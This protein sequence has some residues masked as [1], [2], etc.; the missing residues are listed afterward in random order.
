M[1]MRNVD[2]VVLKNIMINKKALKDTMSGDV[3]VAPSAHLK[4]LN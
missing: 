2:N 1:G 3:E 4:I